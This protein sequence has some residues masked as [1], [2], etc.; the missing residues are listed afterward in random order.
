[1]RR[2]AR[3]FTYL[4]ALFLVAL[5]AGGLALGGEAWQTTVEREKETELL[6]AGNQYRRAIGQYYE[7]TPGDPK[8]YPRT[9][10]D[11]LQDP[12]QPGARRYL[13]KLY[14]DPVTGAKEWG[15]VKAPDDGILGVYSLSEAPPRKVAGFRLRDAGFER[16]KTYADWKFLYTP[17]QLQA[18]AGKPPTGPAAE[19][20][21]AG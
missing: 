17:A 15:L 7:A 4:G 13:R 21:G 10:Q 1:M 14:P 19:P 11:L 6:F 8:R 16:A 2:R 12:R 18:P 3:G 20:T 5:L 9:L